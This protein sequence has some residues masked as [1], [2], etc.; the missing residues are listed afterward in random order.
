MRT[1][2]QPIRR[3]VYKNLT[4]TTTF[5]SPPTGGGDGDPDVEVYT[6]KGKK[7]INT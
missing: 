2:D 7:R 4:K 6:M 5:V 3:D 1:I